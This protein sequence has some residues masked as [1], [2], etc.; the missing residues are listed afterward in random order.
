MNY[1]ITAND[2][3]NT[4]DFTKITDIQFHLRTSVSITQFT[5]E[6]LCNPLAA[7]LPGAN[8]LNCLNDRSQQI[9]I[10]E[11]T[12]KLSLGTMHLVRFASTSSNYLS[13]CPR[14]IHWSSTIPDFVADTF[15]FVIRAA[16]HCVLPYTCQ[17]LITRSKAFLA[18]FVVNY[19]MSDCIFSLTAW[20]QNFS[21]QWIANINRRRQ[22]HTTNVLYWS[23]TNT[24]Q[25]VTP[26]KSTWNRTNV[27]GHIEG[28]GYRVWS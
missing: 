21:F 15:R 19:Q 11:A 6:D 8:A 2:K 7:Y 24:Q 16:I 27:N 3:R 4:Q 12:G 10:L 1:Y 18:L 5:P 28:K 23:R 9:E 17:S 25:L 20:K 22:T 13:G 26:T 14:M